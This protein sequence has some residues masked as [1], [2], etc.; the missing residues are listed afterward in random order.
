MGGNVCRAG[1]V[2]QSGERGE[3]GRVVRAGVGILQGCMGGPEC[4]EVAEC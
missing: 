1:I 4:V 3:Q 2:W